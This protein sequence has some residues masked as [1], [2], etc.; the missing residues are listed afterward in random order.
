MTKKVAGALHDSASNDDETDE[1]PATL[2]P[3]EPWRRVIIDEQERSAIV[4]EFHAAR[5]GDEFSMLYND[6]IITYTIHF[7]R[8]T[9]RSR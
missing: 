1:Q 5:G 6:T 9:S 7:S 3:S 2:T 4:L 8:R